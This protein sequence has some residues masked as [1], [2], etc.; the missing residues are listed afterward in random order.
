MKATIIGCAVVL[1]AGLPVTTAR[2]AETTC[3]TPEH[4]SQVLRLGEPGR[5]G[6]T[7]QI[8]WCVQ[9]GKITGITPHMTHEEDGV[10]CVW[11]MNAEEY[12]RPVPD[13]SGA[14]E[15][16][17]MVEFSCKDAVGKFASVNPWGV[18]T[19]RPDGTSSI[20]AKGIE[21]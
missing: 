8:S 1:F 14:W 4:T 20:D 17:N 2:A 18:I 6:Y 16:F 12:R 10:T 5:W 13:G 19:V 11:V 9:G 15:N 3:P 7:Y 21:R